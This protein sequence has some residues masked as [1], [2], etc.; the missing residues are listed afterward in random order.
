MACVKE[1][2]AV[3]LLDVEDEVIAVDK[4]V[5]AENVVDVTR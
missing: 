4:N 2:S 1:V 5:L 3:A